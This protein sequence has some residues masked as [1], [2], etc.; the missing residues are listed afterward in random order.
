MHDTDRK[1]ARA[2]C[3]LAGK[4]EDGTSPQGQAQDGQPS[5]WQA[6]LPQV[7]AVIE[8]LHKRSPA[9]SE[10]GAT[11]VHYVGAEESDVGHS[12]DAAN[13]WRFIMDVL[14]QDLTH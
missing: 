12:S 14:H 11:I 10:A 2:L 3:R 1:A 5:G 9:I 8:E 13:I 7:R 6:R 4:P